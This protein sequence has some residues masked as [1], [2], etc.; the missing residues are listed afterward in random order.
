MACSGGDTAAASDE[1]CDAAATFDEEV[2]TATPEEQ[3]ELV[4]EMVETA[5]DEIVDEARVFLE[6]LEVAADGD[7]SVVDDPEIKKSVDELNRFASQG[8]ELL[9]GSSPYS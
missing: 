8:C 3:I 1:F 7:E 6:S 9:G 5:P 4:T 2:P